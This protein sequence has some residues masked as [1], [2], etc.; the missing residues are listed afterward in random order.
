MLQAIDPLR[1]EA[2]PNLGHLC[3]CGPIGEPA[4][5]ARTDR[6]RTPSGR[7]ATHCVPG[8]RGSA[9]QRQETPAAESAQ[10]TQNGFASACCRSTHR[11]RLRQRVE[12]VPPFNLPIGRSPPGD[13][14]KRS[15]PGHSYVAHVHLATSYRSFSIRRGT[16]AGAHC[17]GGRDLTRPRDQIPWCATARSLLV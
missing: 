8:G 10:D 11:A 1:Y 14:P 12:G 2:Y 9:T 4:A 5:R 3:R 6:A 17:A 7:T 13:G 15:A 16:I